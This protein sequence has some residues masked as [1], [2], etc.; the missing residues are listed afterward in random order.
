[1]SSQPINKEGSEHTTI[2][3]SAASI[4]IASLEIEETFYSGAFLSFGLMT[5]VRGSF[6]TAFFSFLE[7]NLSSI[8]V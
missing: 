3:F 1:M 5:I 2:S 8:K 6:Q 4:L 7:A